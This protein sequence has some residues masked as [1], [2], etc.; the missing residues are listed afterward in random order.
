MNITI[1]NLIPNTQY[2]I[3]FYS[4][5]ETPDTNVQKNNITKVV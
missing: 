4:T 3:Y 1:N 2:V 5:T